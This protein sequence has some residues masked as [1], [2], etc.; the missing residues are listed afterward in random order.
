[1]N[2]ADLPVSNPNNVDSVYVNNAT[3]MFTPWDIRIL[4]T[5]VIPQP[6]KGVR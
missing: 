3:V 6:P 4:F 5:E 1:M 2:V